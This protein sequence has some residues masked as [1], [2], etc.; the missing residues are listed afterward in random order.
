MGSSRKR[1]GAAVEPREQ[2]ALRHRTAGSG[3]VAAICPGREGHV[4]R[5]AYR[6]RA[7][8]NRWEPCRCQKALGWYEGL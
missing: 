7:G 1:A 5:A 4:A 8:A 3:L 2:A 6:P